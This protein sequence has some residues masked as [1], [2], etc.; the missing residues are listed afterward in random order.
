MQALNNIGAIGAARR[1]W[2]PPARP[3][4]KSDEIK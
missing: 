1:A 3:R 2:K 4:V